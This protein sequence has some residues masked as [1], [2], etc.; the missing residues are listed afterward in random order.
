MLKKAVIISVAVVIVVGVLIT[1]LSGPITAALIAAQYKPETPFAEETETP[2]LDYATAEAWAI[3]PSTQAATF[4]AVR[5][6]AGAPLAERADAAVFFIHPTTY[7]VQ[8][9]WNQPAGSGAPDDLGADFLLRTRIAPG[10]A[11][12]FGACCDVYAPRYRQATFYAFVTPSDDGWAAQERAYQD[13]LTAFDEFLD[14]I[15]P[16]APF[17]L[18]GHSQ[19]AR[20]G[21]QLLEDR[22][23]ATP[24]H[25]RMVA[26]YLPGWVIP[27]DLLASRMPTLEVCKDEIQIGCLSAWASWGEGGSVQ[28]MRDPTVLRYGDATRLGEGTTPICVNPISWRADA[29]PAPRADNGRSLIHPPEQALRFGESL[30]G[31]RCGED[32]FLYVE[33]RAAPIVD[34]IARDDLPYIL[35]GKNFHVYDVPLF[36]ENIAT[37]ASARVMAW[38]AANNE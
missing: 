37:N 8:D 24:V 6:A 11:A 5:A 3:L 27:E 30:T 35:P 12:A 9:R 7:L 32:G 2:A 38:R 17:I 4:D 23:V 33:D 1:V 36:F 18:A 31:A 28:L 26:A 13:V 22:I 15:E 10:M 19:G 29:Q 20:H 14:R 25:D 21:L 34:A 16:D